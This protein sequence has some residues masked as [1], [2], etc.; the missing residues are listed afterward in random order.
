MRPKITRREIVYHIISDINHCTSLNRIKLKVKRGQMYAGPSSGN[1]HMAQG[2]QTSGGIWRVAGGDAIQV[3]DD[4]RRE[5][6]WGA[7]E[8]R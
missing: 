1:R 8:E 7:G 3:N 2:A 6:M 5:R 4:P